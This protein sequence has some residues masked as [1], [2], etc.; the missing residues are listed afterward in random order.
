LHLFRTSWDSRQHG[1]PLRIAQ[2]PRHI[3]RGG[4]YAA[5]LSRSENVE[6]RR[7]RLEA[8]GRRFTYAVRRKTVVRGS[9][10]L[11]ALSYL[12]T[13][14]ITPAS[15]KRGAREFQTGLLLE[16]PAILHDSL[17]G[18]PP[19]SRADND[20]SCDRRSHPL[21]VLNINT[22]PPDPHS[23]ST[24]PQN[25]S[26]PTFIIKSAKDPPVPLQAKPTPSP[27]AQT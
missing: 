19:D 22:N 26:N 25:P 15:I 16:Y 23:G 6:L 27:A 8:T 1:Q 3:P 17:S 10:A 2:L 24:T 7:C 20:S 21:Q 4:Y 18:R 11:C 13:R 5:E 14:D 12:Q 9:V